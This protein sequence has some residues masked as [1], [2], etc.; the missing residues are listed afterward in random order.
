MSRDIGFDRSNSL[1]SELASTPAMSRAMVASAQVGL[2]WA[3]ANAPRSTGPRDP[4]K[5]RYADSFEVQPV[6]VTVDGQTRK[7][8]ALVNT[9][10]QAPY[11]EWVNGAHILARAVDVIERG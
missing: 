1:V 6:D 10:P 7:G 11:V 8:A 3:E 2:N 4:A 5:P 9:S